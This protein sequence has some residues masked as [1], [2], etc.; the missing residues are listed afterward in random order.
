MNSESI[1]MFCKTLMTVDIHLVALGVCSDLH[2]ATLSNWSVAT[3]VPLLSSSLYT[4]MAGY[5]AVKLDQ[6]HSRHFIPDLRD[7][8]EFS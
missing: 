2:N 3:E 1:P 7:R 6:G 4:R 8:R 5:R